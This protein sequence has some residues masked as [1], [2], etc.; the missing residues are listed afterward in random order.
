MGGSQKH[1]T[2]Y[3]ISTVMM[4]RALPSLDRGPIKAKSPRQNKH[5]NDSITSLRLAANH[6]I[7]NARCRTKAEWGDTLEYIKY[8][9]QKCLGECKN[10]ATDV[11]EK[12][13]CKDIILRRRARSKKAEGEIPPISPQS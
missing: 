6:L 5:L 8:T 12:D 10:L 13:T 7:A 3:A 1:E 11:P 4:I 2:R 9:Q